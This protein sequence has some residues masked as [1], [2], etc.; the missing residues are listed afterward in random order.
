MKT[1]KKYAFTQGKANEKGVGKVASLMLWFS[2][3]FAFFRG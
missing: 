2:A 1:I 3:F